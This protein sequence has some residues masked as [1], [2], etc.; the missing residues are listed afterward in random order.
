MF[1]ACMLKLKEFFSILMQKISD[2]DICHQNTDL[3]CSA[4]LVRTNLHK[5]FHHFYFFP[6]LSQ[7]LE[8]DDILQD[9]QFC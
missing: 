1:E 4:S 9:F 6:D 7:S 5:K 8:M 2:T 3:S